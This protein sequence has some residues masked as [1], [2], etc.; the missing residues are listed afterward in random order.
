[1]A[2]AGCSGRR[3]RRH[4][5]DVQDHLLTDRFGARSSAS[6]PSQARQ[7]PTP[8]IMHDRSDLLSQCY[9]L[10]EHVLDVEQ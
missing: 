8:A 3:I 6:R 7:E 9:L 1:M 5:A 10:V 4:F 2:D